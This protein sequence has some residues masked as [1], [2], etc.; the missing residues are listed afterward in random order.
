MK[1]YID[2]IVLNFQKIGGISVYITK[3]INRLMGDKFDFML[4]EQNRVNENILRCKLSV[5]NNI[6]V[7]ENYLPLRLL[8]YVPISISLSDKSVIHSSYYRI[9]KNA[10]AA[11]VITVYDFN[12]ELGYV[13]RGIRKYLHCRQKKYAVNNADGIICISESTMHDLLTMYK[14]ISPEK[15]K[16]IHLAASDEFYKIPMEHGAVCDDHPFKDILRKKYVLFVGARTHHKNFNI[17]VDTLDKLSTYELVIVGSSLTDEETRTLDSRLPSRYHALSNVSAI[18]LN[19][20]YNHAFCFLYP[21]S[22]EG[23]GIPILEAMQAGCPVVSTNFSS[24]PEVAGNAGLLVDTICPDAFADKIL[25]LEDSSYRDK[26]ISAG[27]EQAKKFSWDKTYQ[28]TVEFY[29]EVFNTKFG[30]SRVSY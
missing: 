25:S 4:I 14:N 22:Y 19:Y 24:I 17:C 3:I 9:C 13:R 26:V 28:E 21:S 2:N 16:V 7:T 18:D 5:P 11:N 6:V 29:Q 27:F 15:V 23:F 10:L 30:E 1:I 8:S 20:L 12:Y